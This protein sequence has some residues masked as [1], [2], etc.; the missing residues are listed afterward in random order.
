MAAFNLHRHTQD[1]EVIATGEA[2]QGEDHIRVHTPGGM[3]LAAI[4]WDD[5]VASHQPPRYW[6]VWPDGPPV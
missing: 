4:T 5:L 3:F 6:L 2:V 1:G